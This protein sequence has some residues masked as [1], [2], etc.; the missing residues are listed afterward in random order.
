MRNRRT[1]TVARRLALAAPVLL[2]AVLTVEVL[3]A[4]SA[5]YL[6]TDP[7]YRVDAL[8]DPP[9]RRP[10]SHDPLELAVLGDSTVAGVGSPT[11]A[12]SL[13]VLIGERVAERLRRPV[14]VVGLG[15]SGARTTDLV[16]EQ[17]PLLDRGVDVIVLVIGSNDVTHATPPGQLRAATR[18]LVRTARERTRAVVVLG[19]IPEFATTPALLTPLNVV[20]GLYAQMLRNI[21]R[22]IAS[23]EGAAFVDIARHASPRFLGRP[24]SMSSDGFHPAPLGY[25]FWADAL[26]PA[27]VDAYSAARQTSMKRR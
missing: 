7:G 19:G 6:P 4:A 17:L 13:P 25:G 21:Q 1:T 10:A 8:L 24:D 23:E 12:Q 3:I 15:A 5:E 16:D 9:S 11:A 22:R 18:R 20:T 14:H 26:A 2:G 27:V